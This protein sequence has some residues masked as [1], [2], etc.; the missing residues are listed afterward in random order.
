MKKD[1]KLVATRHPISLLLNLLPRGLFLFLRTSH[2]FF[3]KNKSFTMISIHLVLQQKTHKGSNHNRSYLTC[4][5][6]QTSSGKHLQL[7]N[8]KQGSLSHQPPMLNIAKVHQKKAR[9]VNVLRKL[10]FLS[11]EV[12]AESSQWI[13]H[14]PSSLFL[15]SKIRISIDPLGLAA[16]PISPLFC[17]RKFHNKF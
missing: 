1:A 4:I 12:C 8:E 5:W 3:K 15:E 17:F 6:H 2:H 9:L 10:S 16:L 13:L 11:M 14:A 7:S